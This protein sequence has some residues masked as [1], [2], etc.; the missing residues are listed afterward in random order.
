MSEY[1]PV[2]PQVDLPALEHEVLDYWRENKTFAK[3]LDRVG[4]RPRWT[5]Y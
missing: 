5:F 3:S 4:D 2:P 1:R